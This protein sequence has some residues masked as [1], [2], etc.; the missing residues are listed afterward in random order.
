MGIS[1]SGFK[2]YYARMLSDLEDKLGKVS[3]QQQQIQQQAEQLGQ[4]LAGQKDND[5]DKSTAYNQ[6]T[7]MRQQE[8]QLKQM[9]EQLQKQKTQYETLVKMMNQNLESATKMEDDDMKRSKMM[10]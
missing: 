3:T 9:S 10:A 1:I 4:S 8:Q 7:P 2:V 6:N 5:K